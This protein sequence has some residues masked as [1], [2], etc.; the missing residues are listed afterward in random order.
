MCVL[1]VCVCV[2]EMVGSYVSVCVVYMCE[3]GGGV[4]CMVYV[5]VCS[6]C[7]CIFEYGGEV[8]CVYEYMGCV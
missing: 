2:K 1:Y 3:G 6:M 8:L 7:L 4:L 5:C